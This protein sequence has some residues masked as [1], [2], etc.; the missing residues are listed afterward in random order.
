V[1]RAAGQ[2]RKPGLFDQLESRAS[3]APPERVPSRSFALG[4]IG[5]GNPV[6]A[7]RNK[8][9][10]PPRRPRLPKRFLVGAAA[11][12]TVGIATVAVVATRGGDDK[13]PVATA[14][15]TTQFTIPNVSLPP[16]PPA[17]PG[18]ALS[19]AELTGFW[20]GDWGDLLMQVSPD[21]KVIATYNYDE[22]MII[23]SLSGRRITGWWCEV[24]TRKGP[25][26]AGPVQFDFLGDPGSSLAIDGRWQY[27]SGTANGWSEDWDI[28]AKTSTSPPEVLVDRL[29]HVESDCIPG[30]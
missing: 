8:D 5:G 25:T 29:P 19:A 23:G 9:R 1:L 16:S 3:I 2:T 27:A 13:K 11:V 18:A 22:G 26:D 14:G 28:T 15:Q 20:S 7:R 24:P 12:A 10:R 4:G 21:G 30:A 6:D 17:P